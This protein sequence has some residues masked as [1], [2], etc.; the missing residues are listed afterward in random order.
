MRLSQLIHGA[1]IERVEGFREVEVDGVAYHPE[2]AREGNKLFACIDEYHH[3]NEWATSRAY[4]QELSTLPIVGLLTHEPILGLEV[5]QLIVSDPRRA[6]GEVARL[7]ANCPDRT[8]RVIGVTGTNGKTTTTRLLGH[9]LSASGSACATLGTLGL[10]SPGTFA[11]PSSYTTPLAPELNAYMQR[12]LVEGIHSLAM[13]VSSHALELERVAGIEFSAA[14]LTNLE[15]DHLDFH[16]TLAAYAAAKRKL[17][18]RVRSDGFCVLN[19]EF[20]QFEEFAM[21]CSGNI[22]TYGWRGSGADLEADGYAGSPEGSA[23]TLNWQGRRE[24]VHTAL[25]G[26]FQVENVL[27]AS[28]FLLAQGV[29][30]DSLTEG[31]SSFKPV[32]GRMEQFSLSSGAVAIVDYA[33]NPDGLKNVLLACSE[34]CRGRLHVVFGC[35]GDRDRGKRSEM[36]M[37]AASMAEV[38]WLTSDN[39]R[40]EDP[41][42]ILDDIEQGMAGARRVVRIPDRAEAIR[43]AVEAALPDDL[44]LISGKGHEDYQII[45]L[46]KRPFSDQAVLR[47]MGARPV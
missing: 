41:E 23:F 38:C 9:L 2:N 6:M 32:C 19:K 37:L 1:G 11:Q 10:E 39:P 30:M 12:V 45:G 18:T 13:E 8:L 25:A 4:L 43:Q 28:A 40:T 15:R 16:G 47:A 22:V 21:E 17:F 44:V 46:E 3:S 29:D 27:A 20:S 36:G 35:G 31:I 7:L 26:S 24:L 14:I 33:H 42:A 5:P 34:V